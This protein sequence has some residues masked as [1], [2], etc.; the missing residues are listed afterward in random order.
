MILNPFSG[1]IEF[2]KV[3]DTYKSSET[4]DSFVCEHVPLKYIVVAACKDDCVSQ[5]SKQA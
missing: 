3:F 2:A 1:Q 5:L 4:F